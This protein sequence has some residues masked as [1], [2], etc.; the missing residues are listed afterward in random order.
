M[1]RAKKHA[2][3]VQPNKPLI[4]AAAPPDSGATPQAF[5]A[6]NFGDEYTDRNQVDWSLRVPLLQRMIDQTGAETFLDVGC[7]A[8]W[9]L[10]ALRKISPDFMMSG[11]D[12]NERALAQA[13]SEGFDV[14][15]C[16]AKDLPSQEDLQGAD[17]VITSGVLIHVPPVELPEVMRAICEATKRYI[18]CIEYDAPVET[19]AEYRG[20]QH[21]LWKRPFG[22][23]YERL[24]M[25]VLETGQAEGYVDCKYWLLEKS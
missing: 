5:W 16:A 12:V 2:R 10:L 25:S 3:R 17:M 22:E 20:H 8:G 4:G 19:M 13:S 21:R 1:S 15:A 11:I 18:L 24:G 23:L 7:N 6:G 9:N 14:V